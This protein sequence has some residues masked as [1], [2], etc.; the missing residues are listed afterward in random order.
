MFTGNITLMLHLSI[1]N[2]GIV[3]SAEID[4]NGLTIITGHNDTGKSF[5]GKIIFSIIKT[6]QESRKVYF[7]RQQARVN[8]QLNTITELYRTVLPFIEGRGERY[9]EQ[10]NTVANSFA[11]YLLNG[12]KEDSFISDNIDDFQNLILSDIE[13]SMKE[14]KYS[15]FIKVKN[16]I[17]NT[18]DTV[19]SVTNKI[20]DAVEKLREI[21]LQNLDD[22]TVLKNYFDTVVINEIFNGQI[23]SLFSEEI[24]EIEV[25]QGSTI[26]LSIRVENNT[27]T[28]FDY[29]NE[30]F[31]TDATVIETP[32]IIQLDKY[33]F[34][35]VYKNTITGTMRRPF[36]LHYVDL[37][38]KLV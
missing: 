4:L 23:C 20:K 1:K 7:D 31:E 9:K 17:H 11:Y 15:D 5:I 18:D 10:T 32:T 16:S 30:I 6:I 14:S 36:P 22:E 29:R 2:L 24:L 28:K 35:T 3:K 13:E 8:T 34:R 19:S 25:V 27:T 12:K 21:I 37:L 38:N 33:F 26:L